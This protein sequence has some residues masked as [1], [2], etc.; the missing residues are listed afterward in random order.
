MAPERLAYDRT[1]RA[2]TYR[3][4]KSEGPTVG[5]ETADPLEFLARV[6][7]RFPDNGHVTT[8]YSG[9]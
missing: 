6:V 1:A 5:T 7:V 8:R 2:V 4:D 9:W 3:S